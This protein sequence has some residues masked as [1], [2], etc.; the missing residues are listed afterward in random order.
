MAAYFC[1]TACGFL[2]E[3]FSV[4]WTD[5]GEPLSWPSYSRSVLTFSS[6]LYNRTESEPEIEYEQSYSHTEV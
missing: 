6:G 5:N 1:K 2:N 4:R 3:N